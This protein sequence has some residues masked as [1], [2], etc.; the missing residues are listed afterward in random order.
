MQNKQPNAMSDLSTWLC[1]LEQLH[2]T[3]ID[4]GLER[5]KTVAKRLNLLQPAP[6]VFTVAGTNGKGTTCRTLEMIL[7]EA[8]LQVGVYSSPHLL[9]FT[10]RVRIN[11]QESSEQNTIKAFVEIEKARGDISLTYFEYATLAALYQFKQA[12]LDVVILE[13]GLGGRLDAT[14]IVDADVAVVTTIGIDHVDYLG[15]TRESI[16][17]EKA[18][19]FKPKSIAIV[20]EPEIPESILNAAKLASCPIHAV[21]GDWHYQQVSEDAWTFKS[22]IKQ[23]DNLPIADVPLANA[24]TA[25]AALSYS[26]LK[27]TKEQITKGLAKSKLIGRFQIIQKKPLVILDVAHNPHAAGYLTQQLEK[28]KM[29]YPSISEVRFVVGMLKDK[30]IKSTL[31]IL[32]GDKWYCASL[33]GERGCSAAVLKQHLLSKGEL[34][35]STFDTVSTA[36]QTAIQ[37]AK[38]DD[39][40]VVCGSFHTVSEVLAETEH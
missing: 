25:I 39:I 40:I 10:E 20:G 35:I 22:P 30:D 8:N 19:I 11:N 34:N 7:L 1:Y 24:A 32:K 14:N 31:S 28:L 27:I 2:P 29:E 17:R 5:V 9:R 3:T 23:Y 18:G 15:E 37:D 21:N 16:G 38:E 12:K 4:L 33:Y 36:Y 6:Y 13:V 26:S